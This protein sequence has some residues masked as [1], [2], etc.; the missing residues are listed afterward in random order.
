M[1]RTVTIEKNVFVDVD[2]DL[3]DI[4]TDDLIEELRSRHIDNIDMVDPEDFTRAYE[5]MAR[6]ANDQA[7]SEMRQ[8]IEKAT[9]RI[10][11]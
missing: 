11:P 2:V 3:A 5:L 1:S 4:D 10:L 9:G 6:G 7:F 8:I